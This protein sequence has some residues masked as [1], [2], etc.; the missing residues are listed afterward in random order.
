MVDFV[1]VLAVLPAVV[2][3]LSCDLWELTRSVEALRWKGVGRT[4]IDRPVCRSGAVACWIQR[5]SVVEKPFIITIPTVGFLRER[6]RS[7]GSS[8]MVSVDLMG[9][10]PIPKVEQSF[11]GLPLRRILEHSYPKV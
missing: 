6:I 2:K 11:P 8:L 3:P 7:I 10:S 5:L 4:C 9:I 1:N